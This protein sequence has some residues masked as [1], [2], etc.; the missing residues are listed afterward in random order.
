MFRDIAQSDK[1]WRILLLR[2]FNP[3]AAHPSGEL[4]RQVRTAAGFA[5][6]APACVH[7]CYRAAVCPLAE[8]YPIPTIIFSSK[9]T[10]FTGKKMKLGACKQDVSSSCVLHA[11]ACTTGCA[12]T[13]GVP[14]RVWG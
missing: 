7:V 1:E 5:A 3:V 8:M 2:Y 14:E 13:A 10:T 4:G 11:V 6:A 12:G 9:S